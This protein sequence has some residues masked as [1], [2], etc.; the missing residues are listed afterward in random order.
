MPL[1]PDA[2]RAL[3]LSRNG[4]YDAAKRGEIPTLRF[5]WK[6]VVPIERFEKLLAAS[7]AECRRSTTS[8][9]RGRGARGGRHLARRTAG[10]RQE[11]G[12]D[13]V[14]TAARRAWLRD[15]STAGITP[16]SAFT[17]HKPDRRHSRKP[18]ELYKR[19]ERIWPDATKI[20]L[21][22]LPSGHTLDATPTA[23]E[24]AILRQLRDGDRI[25]IA[26]DGAGTSGSAA[27]RSFPA[28]RSRRSSTR[29]G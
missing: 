9:T 27:R 20:E 23:R 13:L 17:A 11:S 14:R 12:R 26:R 16:A 1:W 4:T 10:R 29:R 18:T 21:F 19:V 24:A 15:D 3:G 7:S 22:A 2:G 5:G 25:L 6:L 28:T 8:R